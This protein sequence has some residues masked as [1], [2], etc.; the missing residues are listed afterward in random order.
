MSIQPPFTDLPT[1]ADQQTEDA[2]YYRRVL[3]ELIDM[4][5]DLA[6]M[7][8]QQAKAQAEAASPGAEPAADPTVG[9]DRIARTITLAR[10]LDDPV[11]A[12]AAGQRVAV[13]KRV[14]R[15]VEDAIHREARGEAAEALHAELLERLDGP[16]IDDDIGHRTVEQIINDI[17]SD[18]GLDGADGLQMWKRRTPEDIAL[19]CARAAKPRAASTLPGNVRAAPMPTW[20]G[21]GLRGMEATAGATLSYGAAGHRGSG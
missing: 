10:T 16:D 5:A 6:R 14:I 21:S 12:P 7:V 9:F 20:V 11:P 1:A 15:M 19:L 4:G 18:L 17:R 3:H 13:R 2:Q 8:H